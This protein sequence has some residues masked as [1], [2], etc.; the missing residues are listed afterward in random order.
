MQTDSGTH[1]IPI[2]IPVCVDVPGATCA[3]RRA[4]NKEKNQG[5]AMGRVTGFRRRRDERGHLVARRVVNVPAPVARTVVEML[6]T[7]PLT[8][9]LTVWFGTWRVTGSATVPS[10]HT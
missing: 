5:D 7:A 9:K 6:D 8:T 4:F 1:L 3:A 2:V 10:P